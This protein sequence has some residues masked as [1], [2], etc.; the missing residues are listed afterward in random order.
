MTPQGAKNRL[1]VA[2]T[3]RR[4]SQSCCYD[5]AARKSSTD[6]ECIFNVPPDYL[7]Q[8]ADVWFCPF[9]LPWSLDDLEYRFG[10]V[11]SE[12]D[13]SRDNL[14][15]K[16]DE[17]RKRSFH[18]TLIDRISNANGNI[19]LA[20]IVAAGDLEVT[21]VVCRHYLNISDA[22]FPGHV[23][24]RNS[25]FFSLNCKSAIFAMECS[26]RCIFDFDSDFSGT[27]FHDR[28]TFNACHFFGRCT[29]EHCAFLDDASFI[30]S[31]FSNE[32]ALRSALFASKAEFANTSFERPLFCANA[33]FRNLADFSCTDPG[34]ATIA[35]GEFVGCKFA[36]EV[37]FE[38]RKFTTQL[39]FRNARFQSA[40]RFDGTMVPFSTIFP[41]V[42]NF[43]DWQR[44]HRLKSGGFLFRS[45]SYYAH[46]NQ[47]SNRYRTLRHL[48]KQQDAYREEAMFWE[49]EMRA[50]EHSLPIHRPGNW[51]L[52]LISI[53]YRI[54]A[55][56]GNSISRPI[57][58]W[59]ILLFVFAI[60]YYLVRAH[61]ILNW[62]LTHA[63]NSY[64]LSF[65]QTVRPFVV[66]SKEGK[67]QLEK[68]ILDHS[69]TNYSA[70]AL[71]TL[72]IQM[73]AT[74]QSVISL[75]LLALLAFAIR[76]R[77]RMI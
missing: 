59:F 24:C 22:Y 58:L 67:D 33:E 54:S 49:L 50:T 66:W 18:D 29:F 19:D 51:L 23:I 10:I 31:K 43:L 32:I 65:E 77:F 57:A 25:R 40:P 28:V 46:Y 11:I 5:A 34:T 69:D 42:E 68:L 71:V 39:D 8:I 53:L 76:R 44:A 47:L 70:N 26:F 20:G 13:P 37:N 38:R 15:D 14:K 63:L 35:W 36:G 27:L 73:T 60:A 2:V 17:A 1:T 75:I 55:R 16:W 30:N 6:A 52:L 9:H 41:P 4:I 48:M 62:D 12:T 7:T 61:S 21:D 74:A 45:P 72:L 3:P 64:G 56:Y